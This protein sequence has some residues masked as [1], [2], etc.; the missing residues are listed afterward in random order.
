M[1]DLGVFS[2]YP[3]KP[4]GGYGDGGM[5]ITDS[6]VLYAKMKR[7][8]FYG[9]DTN[10]YAEEHGYNSRL[11]EIHA[12]ILSRKLKHLDTYIKKRRALAERYNKILEQTSLKLPK[13]D[14]DNFHVFY[15]YVVRHPDRDN[16]MKKLADNNIFVNISYPWPIHI[17]R[18]YSYLGYKEGDFSTTESAAKEIFSLPMYPALT[19]EEQDEVCRV[20]GKIL[21]EKINL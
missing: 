18:G 8:R 5:V 11:D 9:M 4:L 20:L 19:F 2:F 16:I 17:M 21:N 10:Y 7:L 15:I 13:E 6:D 12:E 3:T 1:S 14:S